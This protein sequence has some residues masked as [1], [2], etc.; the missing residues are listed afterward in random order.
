MVRIDISFDCD[1]VAVMLFKQRFWDGLADGSLTV[2][3]RRWRRP[4]VRADGRLQTPAGVLAIDALREVSPGEITEDDARCA[5][6]ASRSS[7]LDELASRSD[8]TLYR[9]DFHHTGSDPRVQLRQRDSLDGDELAELQRRL[10][11]L[12]AASTRGPWTL[13]VLRL[14]AEH[15]GTRAT[16]LA[17]R[18]DRETPK[19]KTDVRKLKNLGLT[20]NLGT[21]YR[22]SPRGRALLHHLGAR[23]T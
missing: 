6:F 14:I 15:P 21:G 20:D 23:S 5:G 18:I 16:D 8:G 22:I 13:A 3:F 19:F 1:V 10:T 2:A 12:D 17:V 11:R 7:L 9:I 4:T